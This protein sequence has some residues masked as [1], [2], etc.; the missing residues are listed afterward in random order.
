VISAQERRW[1][2]RTP[3]NVDII[4]QGSQFH[5]MTSGSLYEGKRLGSS[6]ATNREDFAATPSPYVPAKAK[7]YSPLSGGSY[8]VLKL[9]RVPSPIIIGE[10]LEFEALRLH[11]SS[12][13]APAVTEVKHHS[14]SAHPSAARTIECPPISEWES[15]APRRV[16]QKMHVATKSTSNKVAVA[17]SSTLELTRFQKFIRRMESAG[18]QIILDR[19][20]EEW[21]AN[22]DEEIDEKAS[23]VTKS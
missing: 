8:F 5:A 1:E 19:L 23:S 11:D 9:Y 17:H 4:E 21:Q 12:E 20:K 6:V 16:P 22:P 10:A 18:P 3:V 15:L 2:V 13:P 7:R 14:V